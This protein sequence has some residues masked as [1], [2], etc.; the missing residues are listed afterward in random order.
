MIGCDVASSAPPTVS[1]EHQ[2]AGLFTLAEVP[3]LAMPAGYKRSISAWFGRLRGA[4]AGPHA[5]QNH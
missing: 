4:P 2:R 1:R 3:G 5:R